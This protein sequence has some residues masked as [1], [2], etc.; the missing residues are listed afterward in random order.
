MKLSHV[1][2]TASTDFTLREFLMTRGGEERSIYQFHFQVRIILNT[3]LCDK[4]HVSD[5][6]SICLS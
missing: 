4:I 6:Y 2:E 1:K 3:C 5:F